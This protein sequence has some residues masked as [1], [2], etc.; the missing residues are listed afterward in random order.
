MFVDDVG[1]I[2]GNYIELCDK[3]N[4]W[5]DLEKLSHENI[6]DENEVT[7]RERDG[8]KIATIWMDGDRVIQVK[9]LGI[10]I[11]WFCIIRDAKTKSIPDSDKVNNL[12]LTFKT[13]SL[14]I[15]N[16]FIKTVIRSMVSYIAE[17]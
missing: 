11:G 4:E 5:L 13:T 12:S 10:W 14:E 16:H 3:T 17:N 6:Q 15:K 2:A 7:Q 1:L 9:E 8:E